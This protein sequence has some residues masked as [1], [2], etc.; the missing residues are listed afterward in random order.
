MVPM[1]SEEL[2]GEKSGEPRDVVG[3]GHKQMGGLLDELSA[4]ETLSFGKDVSDTRRLRKRRKLRK[5]R[6]PGHGR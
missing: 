6:N 5:S 2:S 3:V 1:D 4:A